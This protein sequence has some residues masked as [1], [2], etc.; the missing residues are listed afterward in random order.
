MEERNRRAASKWSALSMEEK[1]KFDDVAK[2]YRKPDI[3]ELS[4][5]ERERLVTRHRRQLLAEVPTYLPTYLHKCYKT[6]SK[7]TKL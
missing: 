1:K 2:K 4:Q 5:D 6:L 3:S 7:H